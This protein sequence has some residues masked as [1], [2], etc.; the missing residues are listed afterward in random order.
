M[1]SSHGSS[2]YRTACTPSRYA[3]RPLSFRS[4]VLTYHTQDPTT[5]LFHNYANNATWFFDASST[6][7]LAS[8]VYRLAQLEQIYTYL[9]QAEAARMA[10]SAPAGSDTG[11]TT[12]GTG[13]GSGPA[14]LFTSAL[15]TP[16]GTSSYA[17]PT[18][19]SG[20]Q[21]LDHFTPAMWL[22]PVVDPDNFSNQGG[23]S[24]EGQAFIVEM[25]AAHGDWVT[26]GSLGL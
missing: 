23:S 21:G 18:P 3:P 1:I 4:S 8:T 19:T 13:D 14:T 9:P 24:P 20:G 25:Y 26:L 12:W 11:Y 15:P 16:S 17:V 7:L 2:R 10:L 22:T 5:L 6:A